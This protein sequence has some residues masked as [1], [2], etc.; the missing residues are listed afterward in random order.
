METQAANLI[1]G[2]TGPGDRFTIK[3][4]G[5][6]FRLQIKMISTERLIKIS[7]E[8]CKID[9]TYSEDESFFNALMNHASD[10][11]YICRAIAVSTGTPFVTLVTRALRKLPLKDVQTLFKIVQARSD[12]EIFFYTIASA[13]KLNLMKKTKEE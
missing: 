7:R 5:I 8:I 6:R 9:N 12:A 13:K 11:H 4:C 10:V 2:V 3:W 1:L